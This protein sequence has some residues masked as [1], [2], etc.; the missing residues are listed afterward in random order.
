MIDGSVA[1]LATK[2][3]DCMAIAITNHD[4]RRSSITVFT[5]VACGLHEFDL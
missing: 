2:R 3:N 4:V 1:V 5:E